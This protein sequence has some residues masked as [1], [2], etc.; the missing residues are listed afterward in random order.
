MSFR[1]SPRRG[2]DKFFTKTSYDRYIDNLLALSPLAIWDSG[3]GVYSD[4]GVTPIT[5]NGAVQQLNDLSG[6]GLHVNQSNGANKPTYR[7]SVAAFNNKPALE[8]NGNNRLIRAV[9]GITSNLN[10]YSIVSVITTTTAAAQYCYSEGHDSVSTQ[11]LRLGKDSDQSGI[12]NHISDAGVNMT[13]NPAVD[14]D[15]DN[16]VMHVLCGVRTASNAFELFLDGVSLGTSTAAPGTTTMQ[17][18]A[19]GAWYVGGTYSSH[20]IGH[21]AHISLYPSD[22]SSVILPI[23]NDWY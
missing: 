9:S 4:N 5:A 11:R 17:T 13:I 6:N 18:I 23:L 14:N 7:A 1:T 3:S 2:Y 8:Y 12:F 10:V 22:V 21:I 15:I 19:I 16:G 20:W